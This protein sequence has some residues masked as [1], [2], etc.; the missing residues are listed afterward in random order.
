MAI[1]FECPVCYLT[2]E[3]GRRLDPCMANAIQYT[4]ISCQRL[5]S[6]RKLSLEEVVYLYQVTVSIHGY[7]TVYINNRKASSPIPFNETQTL[8]LYAPSC[9]HLIFTVRKFDCQADPVLTDDKT[10]YKLNIIITI[11]SIARTVGEIEII[12]PVIHFP[13]NSAENKLTVGDAGDNMWL[14]VYKIYDRIAFTSEITVPYTR[15]L[16]TGEVYQY[17][18]Y[19]HGLK[20]YTNGDEIVE[21]GDRGILDPD[22][23]SYLSLFTNGVLQPPINYSVTAGMLTLDTNNVPIST[24]PVLIRFITLKDKEGNLLNGEIYQYNTVSDGIK[25]T[26]TNADELTIY[27][28]QGILNPNHVSFYN[29]YISGVLQPIINYDL[30]EGLLV[31]KTFAVPLAGSPIIVEFVTVKDP[32]SG[33]PLMALLSQYN[34]LATNKKTYTN[35]D[36]LTVY[37]QNG[38]PNPEL[39]SY[40]NLCINGVIQPSI[41]YTVSTGLLTLKTED[42]PL[43]G[44]PIYLQSVSFYLEDNF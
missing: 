24:A 5:H 23:V 27:G 41:N 4:V 36:E 39:S 6:C 9:D 3:T 43:Q 29:V 20:I 16:L 21:Y 31:L 26:Y 34:T 7:V 1:I 11:D 28:N 17:N 10:T 25:R 2:D 8:T 13:S 35:Q 37:G 44:V 33:N 40:Q 18:A 14:D 22:S 19:A 32:A 38:I 12:V 42:P 15:T 30:A